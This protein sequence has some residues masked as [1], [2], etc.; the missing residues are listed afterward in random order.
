VTTPLAYP[1]SGPLIRGSDLHA[2]LSRSM[3]HVGGPV[4]LCSAYMRSE[5]MEPLLSQLPAGASGNVL[6]RWRF[7]DLVGGSSDLAVYD[8]CR[9]Q[10]MQ[11]FMRPQFHGKVYAL[12][13]LGIG[14]GSAN[15]TGAGFGLHAGANDEVCSLVPLSAPSLKLIDDFFVGATR[16]DDRLFAQLQAA[17]SAA[18]P[19]RPIG[20]W[21]L[22][23]K[24]QMNTEPPP[25]RLLV[26]ECLRS[27]GKW[28]AAARTPATELERHDQALLGFDARASI[29]DLQ[30]AL[31]ACALLRW[32]R[33]ELASA[34]PPELYFGNITQLLHS[35]LLDNPGP[36]R[37]EV[38]ELLQHLLS[39][40]ECT[41]LPGMAIDRPQHSQRVR[42]VS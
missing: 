30:H 4:R 11:L 28:A 29:S 38:K 25:R 6:V 1:L 39:W 42:L 15:A 3:A 36:R 23:V 20:D 12:P 32:L 9:R 17:V 14:M 34:E 16:I 2:W 31:S 18:D 41:R 22:D 26:D 5:A 21:P 8:L 37:S 35:A 13:P 27:G 10:G 40:I 7:E 24:R 19:T 33:A